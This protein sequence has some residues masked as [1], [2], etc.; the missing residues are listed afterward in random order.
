[1]VLFDVDFEPAVVFLG[2]F[3]LY[4]HIKDTVL[5]RGF[6]GLRFHVTGEINGFENTYDPGHPP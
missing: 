2:F 3:P 1:M 5:V 4:H 6:S